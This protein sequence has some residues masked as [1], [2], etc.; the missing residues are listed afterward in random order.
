MVI[1]GA[2]VV[3]AAT[4]W[5]AS[6]LGLDVI[7]LERF[8]AGHNRGSS[9]GGVRIFRLAYPQPDYVH[10]A[11]QA[12]HLWRELEAEAGET[13]LE[14][15]GGIDLGYTPGVEAT[16]AGLAAAGVAHEMLSADAAR[17]RFAGFTFDGPVLF[18]PEGGRSWAARSVAALARCAKARS[19]ELHYEEAVESIVV[20][21]DEAEVR[22]NRGSYRAPHVVVAAGAW[23]E[24]V[25]AGLIALPPLRVSREQPAHFAAIDPSVVWPSFIEHSPDAA[26]VNYGLEEPGVGVKLGEHHVGALVHPDRRSFA[27][28]PAA[29]E[30]VRAEARRLLPGVHDEPVAVDTCLY[31]TTGNEDFIIDRVGPITV[32]SACSGHGF[33]FGPATGALVADVAL[34]RRDTLP[35]FALHR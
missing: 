27:V 29:L 6:R 23:V 7:V 26:F 2:G 24:D 18:Q 34:G 25:L 3:G 21:G 5:W 35:R 16:A 9:H 28:D 17:E 22:T 30:R 12:L 31:T 10:L 20:H 1:V 4:A 13:L 11:Q 19:A 33:K 15:T 8:E 32:A 14:L